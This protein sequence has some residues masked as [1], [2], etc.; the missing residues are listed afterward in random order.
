MKITSFLTSLFSFG[1]KN[2]IKGWNSFIFDIN[3]ENVEFHSEVQRRKDCKEDLAKTW[4]WLFHQI[5][6]LTK[7]FYL[8]QP[9]STRTAIL[10]YRLQYSLYRQ[11]WH[12]RMTHSNLSHRLSYNLFVNIRQKTNFTFLQFIILEIKQLS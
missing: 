12:S 5:K 7:T 1:L 4:F 9:G 8:L 3:S 6:F 10:L 11:K 2:E